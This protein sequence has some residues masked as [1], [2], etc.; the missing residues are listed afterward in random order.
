[1]KKTAFLLL[2]FL[3]FLALFIRFVL[4]SL[5]HILGYQSKAGLK[6]T[7]LPEASVFVNGKEVGKT[8]YQDENLKVE[9]YQVELKA[10][11]ASWQSKIKLINGTMA[12]INREL[13]TS[14]AS[15]SGE[16]LTLD[17]GSGVIITSTPS[18]AEVEI[19]GRLVGKT[20]LSVSTLVSGEHT[21]LLSHDGY[22][23][24]NIRASLPDG[25]ALTINVNMAISEINLGVLPTPEIK[26]VTKMV[27]KQTPTGFLRM[28]DKPSVSGKEVAK[29]SSGDNLILIEDLSSWVKVQTDK[30]IEGYVSAI[31]IQKQQ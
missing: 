23:K 20:P 10:G 31:Y 13:A 12:V 27:V 29:L 22:L 16:I 28:R 6:I 1:M 2:I 4:P 5:S 9:E 25:L 11:D 18:S 21:F 14:M 24:R 17:K 7:S 26:A 19:D 30:G 3:S 8:P 15:S